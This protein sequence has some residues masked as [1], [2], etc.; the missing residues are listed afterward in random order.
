MRA[1]RIWCVHLLAMVGGLIWFDAIWPAL[2]PAE[3][4]DFI[5]ILWGTL[6]IITLRV[7]VE[8]YISNHR[9]RRYRI[10]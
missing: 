8:E 3:L 1:G 10:E 4:R 7:S 2:I 6:L 5:F 9:L